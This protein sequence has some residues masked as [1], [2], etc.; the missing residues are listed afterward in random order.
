MSG[1]LSHRESLVAA[2]QVKRGS[3]LNLGAI[4]ARISLSEAPSN[5]NRSC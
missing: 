2:K 3:I 5:G 4:I 1:P